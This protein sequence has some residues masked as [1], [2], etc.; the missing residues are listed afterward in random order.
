MKGMLALV[1]LAAFYP[2]RR[3]GRRSVPLRSREIEPGWLVAPRTP[4]A[5]SPRD[6]LR[7]IETYGILIWPADTVS[8]GRS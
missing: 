2:T 4:Q 6:D 7:T 1:A 5:R 3:I 8:V